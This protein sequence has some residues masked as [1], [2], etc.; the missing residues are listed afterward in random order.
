MKSSRSTPTSSF[1]VISLKKNSLNSSQFIAGNWEAAEPGQEHINGFFY[2]STSHLA[3]IGG[4]NEYILTYGWD[5]DDIYCR[6]RGIGLERQLVDTRSIYHMEHDDVSRTGIINTNTS[7]WNVIHTKPL[8]R[9][10]K[11][12]FIVN[13]APKWSVDREF[14]QFEVREK[15]DRDTEVVR[16]VNET[17]HYISDDIAADS[18]Y[19]AAL[20]LISWRL[21]P[22]VYRVPRDAFLHVIQTRS[23]DDLTYNDL[24]EFAQPPAKVCTVP[25]PE[26]SKGETVSSPT[27]VTTKPKFYIDTQHGLGNRLRA[28]GSAAAISEATDRK[29][30]IVSS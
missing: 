25:I 11:N 5:D 2:V 30:L 18:E 4:F 15:R 19:Y 8:F 16:L 6:L 17:P 12:R 7:A 13:V 22:Q 24:I 26:F 1:A 29:P 3:A 23:L 9:I 28:V 14:M 27:F 10:R 20:E 21:G